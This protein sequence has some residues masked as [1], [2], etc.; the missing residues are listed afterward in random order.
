MYKE[1]KDD[2]SNTNFEGE[3]NFD[4]AI[5]E[6]DASKGEGNSAGCK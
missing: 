4:N 3:E 1:G 5:S 2:T 6:S